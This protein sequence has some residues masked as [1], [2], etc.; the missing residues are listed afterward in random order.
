MMLIKIAWRN[1]WRNKTRS[2]II[3]LA[4]ALGLWGGIFSDAFMNGMARQQV[5]TTIHT[6]TG[7]I[8]INRSGFRL[9]RDLQLRIAN[10]DSLS[11]ALQHQAGVKAIAAVTQLTA[12]VS[13]TAG[14]AGVLLNGID[15]PAYARV[16]DLPEHLLQG[17]FFAGSGS[18]PALI[19]Q[20]LADKLHLKLHSRLVL[21]MQTVSGDITYAS[22][23][24]TGIFRTADNEYDQEML[25][26]RNEDLK[27]VIGFPAA[28]ASLL[29]VMLQSDQD[30]AGE[31]AQLS[32]HLAGLQVQSWEQLSP[33]LELVTGKTNLIT[34]IFVGII[35]VAL[36]FGIV[37]TML[38][39]VL[40]RTREI[41]MLLAIGMKPSR[42][43]GMI[44]LETVFLSATGAVVGVCFGVAGIAWFG[45]T[46]INLSMIAEGF[47]ALGYS[48]IVYP[49]L[50][51][52]FYLILSGMVVV[53]ALV[54]GWVPAARAMRLRPAAAIRGT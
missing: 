11:L 36:A 28:D 7:D 41:G 54:A 3:L 37:N 31:A 9:N 42:I 48:S 32:R 34:F 24:V 33:V 38:M 35:L 1:V 43:F 53:I 50:A 12:M 19:S 8:Q 20:R 51:P 52:G 2:L 44:L 22:F 46:G 23:R 14:S 39:A 49:Y 47:N 10:A 30:A 17:T 25:F 16:S 5:Y 45:R 6:E 21:T 26:V 29:V 13:T 15:A 27:P 40:D 18:D 4:V